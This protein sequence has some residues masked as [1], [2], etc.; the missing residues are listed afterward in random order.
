MKLQDFIKELYSQPAVE[1]FELG[2]VEIDIGADFIKSESSWVL[3]V[4][5]MP[6]CAKITITP[7]ESK[8][9]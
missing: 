5:E 3:T 2:C 9:C 4:G 7:T 8:G 6:P 1:G